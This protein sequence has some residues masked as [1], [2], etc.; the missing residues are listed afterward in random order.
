MLDDFKSDIIIG[1]DMISKCHQRQILYSV[2]CSRMDHW[3]ICS[4]ALVEVD[5]ISSAAIRVPKSW[6]QYCDKFDSILRKSYALLHILILFRKQILWIL[7]FYQNI[8]RCQNW[9]TVA[10]LLQK[11]GRCIVD[12][13][14]VLDSICNNPPLNPAGNSTKQ[15]SLPTL[16]ATLHRTQLFLLS[17][18]GNRGTRKHS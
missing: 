2:K 6:H 14:K 12:I 3:N 18:L 13:L 1:L 9:G 15:K 4:I 17:E 11:R 5:W 7:C 8:C 10:A 16:S